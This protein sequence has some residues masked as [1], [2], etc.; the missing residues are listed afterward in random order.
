MAR[1][2]QIAR[3][4]IEPTAAP[5]MRDRGTATRAHLVEAALDHISDFGYGASTIADIAEHAGIPRGSVFYYFPTKDDIVIAAIESYVTQAHARRIEK[6]LGRWSADHRAIDRFQSYF[7]SRLEARR[8]TNFRRGCLLGNLAGEIGRP[9]FAV[10]RRCGS[11]RPASVRKGYPGLPHSIVDSGPNREWR[12]SSGAG[13]D[14]RKRLGRR[15]AAHEAAA[16]SEAARAVH[17]QLQ[18]HFSAG[19][20]GS[21]VACRAANG[22]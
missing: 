3:A 5:A 20:D 18:R 6:L 4:R 14:D 15:A 1:A 22:L 19:K 8:K 11:S 16:I 2:T 17:D 9:R 21:K 7:R 10:G 12:G 13:G